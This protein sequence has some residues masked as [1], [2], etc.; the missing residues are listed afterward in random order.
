MK[1]LSSL[2]MIHFR[3]FRAKKFK[4]KHQISQDQ[5]PIVIKLLSIG[6]KDGC[7]LLSNGKTV[8]Q[9]TNVD[10]YEGEFD[11]RFVSLKTAS[12]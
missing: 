6:V 8:L 9:S 3:W 11:I 1:V 2:W 12:F 4:A 10:C 5:E 7:P